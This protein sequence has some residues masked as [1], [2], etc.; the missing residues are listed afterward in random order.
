MERNHDRIPQSFNH[1]PRQMRYGIRRTYHWVSATWKEEDG[2]SETQDPSK[3]IPKPYITARSV[4]RNRDGRTGIA[5][6][7]LEVDVTPVCDVVLQ[8]QV[9]R[10]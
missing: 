10:V 2:I 5:W 6:V 1:I 7:W 4:H 8:R 9:T 3:R